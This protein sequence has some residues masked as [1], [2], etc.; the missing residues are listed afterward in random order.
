M[1]QKTPTSKEDAMTR[2]I[3]ISELATMARR[4]EHE[5]GCHTNLGVGPQ[6]DCPLCPPATL[7]TGSGLTLL[8]VLAPN[9]HLD[10]N[11]EDLMTDEEL[12]F[13]AEGQGWR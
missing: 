10:H 11:I 12:A 6:A 7:T 1:D 2:T 9:D 4:H 3:P 8:E 13:D 5:G